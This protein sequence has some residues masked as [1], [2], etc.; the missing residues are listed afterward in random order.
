MP[1]TPGSILD[2]TKSALGLD[3]EYQVFDPD[4]IMHINSVFSTLAQIGVGP[5]TGFMITNSQSKWEDFLV[6]DILLNNVKTYT[7]LR[8]RLLFDP[9]TMGYLVNA[10]QDQ[11]KELEW[12]INVQAEASAN[13]MEE[14]NV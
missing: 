6:G 13:P 1:E 8:V 7:Y 9:P 14:F 5:K 11:V 12:R 2:G 3:S 4:I 10:I